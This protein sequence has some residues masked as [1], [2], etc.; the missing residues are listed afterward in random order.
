MARGDLV[1]F[2]HKIV[3][4]ASKREVGDFL[5]DTKRAASCVPGVEEVMAVEDGWYE[6]RV[7]IKVGPLG[8]NFSGRARTESTGEDVWRMHG[9][10]RDTR[11]SSGVTAAVEAE[12]AEVDPAVTEV[13]IKADVNFSG[14]LAEM[15]QPLIRRKAD[16]L[17]KEFAKNLEEALSS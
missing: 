2:E 12:L 7:R 15:G 5:N 10:G 4:A 1:K 16:S 3:V 11:V 8:M 17:V 14:R 13:S 6:G 9:E